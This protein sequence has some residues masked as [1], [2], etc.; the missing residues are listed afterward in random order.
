M[1]CYNTLTSS[2]CITLLIGAISKTSYYTE[3]Y[4]P[5]TLFNMS[6]SGNESSLFDCLYST[7][8]TGGSNCYSHEDA[9]VICQGLSET[10]KHV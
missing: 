6:C 5:H 1:V 2:V 10:D 4:L 7:K 8:V 9:A 3:Y